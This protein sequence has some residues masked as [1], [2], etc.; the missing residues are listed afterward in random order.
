MNARLV[1]IEG[2]EVKTVNTFKFLGSS[3]DASEDVE[4][5]ACKQQNKNVMVKVEQQP[6][7]A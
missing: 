1:Y 7:T 2:K 5:D 3:F 6:N 4:K